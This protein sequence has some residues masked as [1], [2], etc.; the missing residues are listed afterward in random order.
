MISEK[1]KGLR[2]DFKKRVW[3]TSKQKFFFITLRK[4]FNELIEASNPPLKQINSMWLSF[5][6]F[7]F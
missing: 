4:L 7:L 6:E 3:V 2:E 5:N 1:I